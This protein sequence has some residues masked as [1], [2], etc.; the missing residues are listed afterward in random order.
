LLSHSTIGYLIGNL[1]L[2][3][4]SKA[5][6]F[7][8]APASPS[9]QSNN[10]TST[11]PQPFLDYSRA[12]HEYTLQRWLQALK[13]REEKRRGLLLVRQHHPMQRQPAQATSM[14]KKASTRNNNPKDTEERDKTS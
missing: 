4:N 13:A 6:A 8:M 12:L 1:P 9:N 3:S 11:D 10:P 5:P 7:F 14:W 2:I